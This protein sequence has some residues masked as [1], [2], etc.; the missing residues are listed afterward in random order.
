MAIGDGDAD[1]AMIPAMLYCASAGHQDLVDALSVKTLGIHQ[2]IHAP[3]RVG[4]PYGL[5]E[6][7]V[8]EAGASRSSSG[9][10]SSIYHPRPER[11]CDGLED[12]RHGD[13]WLPAAV[14]HAG[15]DGR[16][17]REGFLGISDQSAEDVAALP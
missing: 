10:R 6:P 15:G 8:E 9:E 3:D 17:E 13:A 5:A 16:R 14:V 2:S 12:D 1:P 7:V 4:A 11:G